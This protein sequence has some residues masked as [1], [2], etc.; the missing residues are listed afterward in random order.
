MKYTVWNFLNLLNK[1]GFGDEEGIEYTG[2]QSMK[3][4]MVLED[5]DKAILV[6][7]SGWR[8]K[9]ARMGRYLK[10]LD[11]EETN[12]WCRRNGR[13]GAW[14]PSIYF[15]NPGDVFKIIFEDY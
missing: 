1:L 15:A 6:G 7:I 13:S 4:K 2:L 10:A 14:D 9:S 5:G 8:K 11:F 3:I 12:V